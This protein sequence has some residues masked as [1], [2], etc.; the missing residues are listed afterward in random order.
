LAALPW[1]LVRSLRDRAFRAML[2]ERLGWHPPPRQVR[3]APVVLVHGVSVGEVKGALP[4]VRGIEERFPGLEVV[5]SATTN[6][7]IGVARELFPGRR[8]VRFPADTSRAVRRFLER[9]GAGFVVLVELEVWPN[10]LR[11]CNRR[12][13]PVVVVN[14]RITEA[15]HGR[16]LVFRKLLPQ[17]NRLSLLCVQDEGYARRFRDLWVSPERV[18]VTGSLKADRLSLGAAEPG[19]ELRAL[20]GAPA[21]VPVIV[22][23]STHEPE[24]ALVAKAWRSGAP[25]TR[26]LIVPRHPGRAAEIARELGQAGER[27]QRLTELRAQAEPPDPAR[28]CVVDT[29]GEL[30]RVY[31]LADVVFVGG[32]LI[33][34]GG[35]NMLE[36]AAQG[37]AVIFGPHVENFAREAELL[38]SSGACVQVRDAEH[39]A[40]AFGELLA[41]PERR[42]RMAELGLEVVRT[43][44]GATKR[45][46]DALAA[47]GLGAEVR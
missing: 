42:A 36:P 44:K 22:A 33:P 40:C 7:G 24:E 47:L 3:P 25:G 38:V 10:F 9:V 4:L 21:G 1:L 6:T 19:A 11:E 29:M 30:E 16:Y 8:V 2:A 45:T 37:K 12:G 26:L 32:S 23:G 13:A 14:G 5:V 31:G 34:H 46:L 15:S 27:V 18:V 43:Q 28:P 20:L 17:F 39:L 41:A 35:Q